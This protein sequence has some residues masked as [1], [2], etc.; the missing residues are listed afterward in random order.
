M[1][2]FKIKIQV[3]QYEKMGYVLKTGDTICQ[4]NKDGNYAIHCELLKF[5]EKTKCW[6]GK[7]GSFKTFPVS[8]IDKYIE[9]IVIPFDQYIKKMKDKGHSKQ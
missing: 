1:T 3:D 7:G 9:I 4:K 8:M 2:P 6:L 5:D